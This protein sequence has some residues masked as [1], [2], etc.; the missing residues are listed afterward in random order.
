MKQGTYQEA[1]DA[2]FS[3]QRAEF[4]ARMCNETKDEMQKRMVDNFHLQKRYGLVPKGA[5]RPPLWFLFL[6]S[7]IGFFMITGV[8]HL[9]FEH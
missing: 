9:F 4:L 1:I 7:I 8:L 2:G 3:K 5:G 6:V